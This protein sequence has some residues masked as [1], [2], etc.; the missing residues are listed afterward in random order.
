MICPTCRQPV[1]TQGR[2]AQATGDL[3]RRYTCVVCGLS[4]VQY[5]PGRPRKV[6]L[7]LKCNRIAQQRRRHEITD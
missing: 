3:E 5:G 4:C 1:T 6:C 2:G 7:A